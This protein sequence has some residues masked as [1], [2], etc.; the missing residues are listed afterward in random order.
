L[1]DELQAAIDAGVLDADEPISRTV[2]RLMYH[3]YRVADLR[4][5]LAAL[6]SA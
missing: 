1:R 6:V 5:E 2:G 3:G 4:R